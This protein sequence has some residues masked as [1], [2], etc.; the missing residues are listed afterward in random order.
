M[1]QLLAMLSQAA[2]AQDGVLLLHLLHALL[3]GLLHGVRLAV[4]RVRAAR[5]RA[6]LPRLLPIQRPVDHLL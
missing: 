2:A 3:A 4:P 6:H 1:E 5:L